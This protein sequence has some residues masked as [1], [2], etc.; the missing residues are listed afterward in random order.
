MYFSV[1][2]G[3]HRGQPTVMYHAKWQPGND[4]VPQTGEKSDSNPGLRDKIPGGLP[5]R[6]PF[7]QVSMS[8]LV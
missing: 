4:S 5:M 8:V 1:P 7:S 2:V 3:L 6:Y